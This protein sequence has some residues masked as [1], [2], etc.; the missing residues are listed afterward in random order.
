MKPSFT[1]PQMVEDHKREEE[2]NQANRIKA[3]INN[4]EDTE[5]NI[6][7]FINGYNHELNSYYSVKEQVE[8]KKHELQEQKKQDFITDTILELEVKKLD[9]QINEIKEVTQTRL[10]DL[11]EKFKNIY[12]EQ[13]EPKG[14]NLN[15][16]DVRLLQ[17]G[18]ELTKAELQTMA[19]KYNKDANETMKRIIKDYAGK[20]GIRI[21]CKQADS[22][23]E[24]ID[25]LMK[26]T[27]EGLKGNRYKELSISNLEHRERLINNFKEL[28]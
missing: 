17:S 2:K 4:L 14:S 22:Y 10:A 25:D 6:G 11:S 20:R 16:D 9:N 19:D 5:T 12:A 13:I 28:L 7:N 21:Y 23:A 8:N 15:D 27:S 24:A 1:T 18:I 3:S 26:L